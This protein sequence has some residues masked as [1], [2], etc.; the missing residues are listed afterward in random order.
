[1]IVHVD[2]KAKELQKDFKLTDFEAL[3][4]ACKMQ[5]NS[6]LTEALVITGSGPG[7]IEAIAIELG[8]SSQFNGNSIKESLSEIANS[9]SMLSENINL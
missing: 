3:Q 9:I 4:I 2:D 8:A 5:Y 6:I 7:A 1:M